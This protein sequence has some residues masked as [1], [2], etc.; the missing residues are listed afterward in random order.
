[1]VEWVWRRAGLAET[2]SIDA[3]TTGP[4]PEFSLALGEAGQDEAKLL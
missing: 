1:M 3:A 2:R 4:T